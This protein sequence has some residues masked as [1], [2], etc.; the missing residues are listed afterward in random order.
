MTIKKAE[1]H[2]HLEGTISPSLAKKLAERNN[3]NLDVKLFAADGQSY[4]Y[5]NFL[6]FLRVYDEIAKVIQKPEDYY[7]IT[8]NYLELNARKG[9]IYLETMYSPDHAE[10]SSGIPSCEHLKAIQQAI[11]DAEQKHGITGRIIITAVRHYGIDAAV[12]VAKQAVKEDMPYIVGFGLGGDEVNYPPKLFATAYQIAAAGGLSCTAH[13]GEF[14]GP[15]GI[16]EALK[17]LPIKRI[18]HGVQAI[19]SPETMT[20]LKENNIAL[21]VCPSSNIA[22]GLFN[23]FAS[24]PLPEFIKAGLNVSLGSDDPPFFRTD[25]AREYELVQT[26]YQYSDDEMRAFTDRAID[27]SFADEKTKSKLRQQLSA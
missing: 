10:Q 24:H 14:A 25:V 11:D 3:I 26:H 5:Q 16:L 8:Y 12:K 4:Q 13:A 20:I 27:A 22:L 19:H 1:L 15:S 23:D 18:G 2:S 21:E 9:V 6:D 17:Y 7:D